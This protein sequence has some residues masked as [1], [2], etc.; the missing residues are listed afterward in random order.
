MADGENAGPVE[1]E[2]LAG[3]AALQAYAR[4]RSVNDDE[5]RS[6]EPS[7]CI[8][9]LVLQVLGGWSNLVSTV[10][11]ARWHAAGPDAPW[12]QEV[13]LPKAVRELAEGARVRWPHDDFAAAAD[14]A[15]DVRHTLAHMLFIRS[16]SGESPNQV[17][18]FVRLGLPGQPRMVNGSPAELE[19]RDDQ[20]SS[21]TIHEARITEGEL[22][23]AL[24]E[25]R[26]MWESVRALSRLHD[27]LAECADLADDYE[28]KLYPNGGWWI[29]W[30]PADWFNGSHTPT[31]G[32]VRLPADVESS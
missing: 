30:A 9:R 31:I 32:D 21:Q 13:K 7:R 4:M 19:W 3:Q 18:C 5:Q 24:I 10:N 8:E 26:W 16:I 27:Q 2:S 23:Q 17:L 25:I 20:S 28:L 12:V 14:H 6:F 29:P 11:R 1:T 22:R 15:G